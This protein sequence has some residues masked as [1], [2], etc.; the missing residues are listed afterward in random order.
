MD[1]YSDKT[2]DSLRAHADQL[3]Q[4]ADNLLREANVHADE[5]RRRAADYRRIADEQQGV[6]QRSTCPLCQQPIVDDGLGWKHVEPTGCHAYAAP[7]Y[8]VEPADVTV[9]D[10]PEAA[11][12]RAIGDIEA[13]PG[14][15]QP[16]AWDGHGWTHATPTQCEALATSDT[17]EAAPADA[18]GGA[19]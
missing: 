9:V 16:I 17:P 14:C 4:D 10:S 12:Q 13:C 8:D 1:L 19:S 15:R 6:P 11:P 18:P 5:I 3:D 7:N 2:P